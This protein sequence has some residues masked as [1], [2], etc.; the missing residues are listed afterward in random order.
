MK[1]ALYLLSFLFG[2]ISIFGQTAPQ[3][4]KYQGVARNGAAVITGSVGLQLTIRQGTASGSVAYRERHFPN[5]NSQGVFSVNVGQGTVTAGSFTGID[6]AADDYFLQVELD[7]SGGA[8]YTDLGA[9]QILSVPYAIY[10]EKAGAVDGDNDGDPSNEI[11]ALSLSGAQLSLSNG[12]GSVSLPTGTTYTAGSGISIS[13]NIISNTGDAD[14]SVTNEIQQITLAGTMLSLS[15]GG[16]SVTLPTGTTYTAGSGIGIAGNVISNTGDNDNSATNEIQQMS[17]SGN[18]LSLNN[19]GNTVTLP[20]GTTYTAGSGIDITGNNISATDASTTNEIQTLSISGTVLSLS[21]GGGSVNLPSGPGGGDNWGTQTVTTTPVLSGNGT[22]ANPLSIAQN[23]ASN[24]EALV[25]NGSTWAPAAVSGGSYSAGAG[26]NISG[27]TISADDTSPTNETQQLSVSGN[28]L[29][30]N[31]GGNT[32][33]LP[34][35]TTY[36]AGTGISISGNTISNT[37]DNDNSPTNEVQSLSVSGNQLSISGGNTVTMPTG[38]TYTAGTGINISGNAINSTWTASGSDIYNN[39]T[40]H[41]AV[42]TNS[43]L[44]QLEVNNQGTN[45]EGAYVAISNASNGSPAIVGTTDGTGDGVIGAA[46]AGNGV[47]ASSVTGRAG[48]F[49]NYDVNTNDYT[50]LLGEFLGVSAED[51]IGVRGYSVPMDFYGIGG[52]FEGGYIGLRGQI[53][54]TGSDFYTGIYG[55]ASGGSGTNQG[56]SGEAFGTG[57]N[58]GVRGSAGGG[59]ENYGVFGTSID[60]NG[61]YG[62]SDNN[63][64]VVAETNSS[65]DAAMAAFNPNWDGMVSESAN[66]SGYAIWGINNTA[67]GT[68]GRFSG[69]VSILGSLSKSSGTFKIDHPLDPANKYLYHSFVESPDMMN[70]YNGNATTD[71]NGFAT[72]ELP[73]YFMALNMDYR[74]QLTCIGTFAQAIVAQEVAD[75]K[76]VLQTDK[77]NVK[78]SWQVTGIRQDPFAAQNRV[79]PEVEKA[80]ENKGQY[81]HPEVYGLP[82]SMQE[83]AERMERLRQQRAANAN[84]KQPTDP[85]SKAKKGS[86]GNINPATA[87]QRGK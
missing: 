5:T 31:N 41:V 32:V 67:T 70:V 38:T 47:V 23:G 50:V 76:F 73:S 58:Y 63:A 45:G 1:K 40:G 48:N 77:P 84:A 4:F 61:V 8:T 12:G 51:M 37:G 80:P 3:S 83:D 27:N 75:N 39:N 35:G 82:M 19:G 62:Y 60:G 81:L 54:P 65:G 6:W 59:T 26:I 42:G 64:A 7:P 79:Q 69:N 10:A 33:T 86:T 29:T 17:V 2:S 87:P 66:S 53:F 22:G 14:N 72:V 18:Q 49:F 24:G 16:G 56:M 57:I 21:S 52:D 71:A 34:T 46:I 85:K 13:G 15:N 43:A 25:W 74:Y 20:T 28:Q 44:A 55:N 78:V 36:T 9:S 30:L 11:Q 68:A